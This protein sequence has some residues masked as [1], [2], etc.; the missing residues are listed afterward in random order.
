MVANYMH[1]LFDRQDESATTVYVATTKH[2]LL[3][4]TARSLPRH[5]NQDYHLLTSRHQKG[6]DRT[7]RPPFNR[8]VTTASLKACTENMVLVSATHNGLNIT[9]WAGLRHFLFRKALFPMLMLI[10][11]LMLMLCRNRAT[12]ERSR[13][14]Y[15]HVLQQHENTILDSC[16]F[17]LVIRVHSSLLWIFPR[18]RPSFFLQKAKDYFTDK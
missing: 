6:R 15:V 10:L 18:A 7:S 1:N 3:A 12:V 16:H 2:K 9:L 8:S 14:T 13:P 17:D 4:H 5:R 11:M